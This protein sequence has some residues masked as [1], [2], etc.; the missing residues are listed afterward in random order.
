MDA[1]SLL[2]DLQDVHREVSRYFRE[3]PVQDA[4]R[5]VGEAWAPIDDL[6]HLTLSTTA[7]RR[8]LGLPHEV[9][10]EKFGRPEAP[11]RTRARLE[12]VY[13][14]ALEAGGRSVAAF[15]PDAIPESERT[16]ETQASLIEEWSERASQLEG[17]I[18]SWPDSEWDQH[19]LPHPLLGMLTLRE[20]VH[21][22]VLHA[23]HHLS[24]A[25]RRLGRG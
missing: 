8:A 3:L 12:G 14:A 23:R 25:E 17:A 18:G 19:Q 4:Y 7:L 5:T 13:R 24:V 16:E 10:D 11:S 21:F 1:S 15:V 6:R 2:A 9:M 22:N 20:W